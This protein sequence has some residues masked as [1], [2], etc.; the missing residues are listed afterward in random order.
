VFRTNPQASGKGSLSIRWT[1]SAG[2]IVEDRVIAAELVDETE[3]TF[4]LDMRRAVTLQNDLEVK[5]DFQGVD[6]SGKADKRQE[7]ARVGFVAKPPDRRWWDYQIVMWQQHTPEMFGVLKKDFG[8]TAGQYSGRAMTPPQFLLSNNLRWYAE[9]IATDFYAEYHRYR[10][11]RKQNW[12]FTEAKELY[13]RNPS[14]L[15]AFKRHPSLSDPAW[16][17]KIEQRLKDA[18]RFHS[19]YRPL[20]YDLGDESGIADLAS[21]WD[22]D[23]SDHSL[24][25]M[26]DWLQQRYTSLAALNAQWGSEFTSWDRVVPETTNQ[27]MKRTDNNFSSW[28]DHKEWMDV[29]FARALKAGADAINSVDPEAYVAIAGAQMPGWGGYDYYRLTAALSA[30]EPYNIGSNVEIIRSI[31]PKTVMLTT[32]FAKGPWEK[33]R[34]WY[35]LLHGSR[36]IIIWDDKAEYVSRNDL[37]TGGRGQ[38]TREY[39]NELRSG[40]AALLINS[41][42][43]SDPVAIHYS[44]RSMRIEWM[45]ARQPEGEAWVDRTSATERMDSEFL[46]LRDS[47]C[48]LIED[49]GLQYDFVASQQ[50]ES[51]DLLRKGFRVLVLPRST[52]LSAKEADEIK[53]FA[54]QGGVVVADGEPGRYDEHARLLA[55][56]ALKELEA[57][58][59]LTK[60]AFNT[61]DYHQHRLVGKEGPA[62]DAVQQL[63]AK[64]GV[65]AEFRI[66]DETGKPPVGVELHRFRNGGVTILALHTNP[67]LRVDELGPPEFKSNERFE[68]PQ[69][70]TLTLP[71]SMQ[72][73]DLRTGKARGAQKSVTVAVDP[74]EPTLFALAPTQ[75]PEFQISAPASGVRGQTMIV[76]MRLS[77]PSPADQHVYRVQCAGPD[78]T[79][80]QH[81]SGNVLAAG[82]T[83]A[84]SIPLAVNDAP[85][86]WT[87]RVTDIVSGQ[88]KTVAINVE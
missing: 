48:R 4:A 59:R 53:R 27:A 55:Q 61:L 3:L 38:Q 74:Y 40:V 50:I 57:S 35:E 88:S 69:T 6:K 75:F 86:R 12:S 22:F 23:F 84:H 82:G 45:L 79:A 80:V 76:G 30:L 81:Y 77:R 31:N 15:E 68:K 66:A 8:I 1:D 43:Q 29:A 87:V 25:A 51:G 78:G 5:F 37:K 85:G 72:L 73:L 32:A 70:V 46:R 58:G 33:H 41:V 28:S 19:Q 83:A 18:A 36:G 71:G 16:L 63:L 44:Q 34:V 39:Y 17:Q 67:Q 2:R 20:F 62:H 24:S 14:S 47:W 54:A 60:V 52:A 26:R 10:R 42:R 9:N 7:T 11:D 21:F 49:A 64:A 65:T 13:K 56:P